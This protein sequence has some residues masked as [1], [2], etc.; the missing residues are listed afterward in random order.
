M[1]K[2][3]LLFEASLTVASGLAG[4]SIPQENFVCSHT[5]HCSSSHQDAGMI[6]EKIYSGLHFSQGLKDL[7]QDDKEILDTLCFLEQK[8]PGKVH[9]MHGKD[10]SHLFDSFF[11]NKF[12][13][14][15][16]QQGNGF[17]KK[18]YYKKDTKLPTFGLPNAK[19]IP[20]KDVFCA[21][22]D[23]TQF[24]SIGINKE[25]KY[26]F[27][28]P[29]K[30]FDFLDNFFFPFA[31]QIRHDD[32]RCADDLKTAFFEAEATEIAL[33]DG[34]CPSESGSSATAHEFDLPSSSA[35]VNSSELTIHYFENGEKS[36]YQVRRLLDSAI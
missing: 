32:D 23:T 8:R 24:I 34:P 27:F 3:G 13:D 31:F 35:T 14:H 4:V 22:S 2:K 12:W 5:A 33:L 26:I 7:S 36:I 9:L 16:S 29:K 30:E 10:F 6:F 20:I 19:E 1:K 18:T 11:G 17:F 28:L 25:Y 15:F 21:Y